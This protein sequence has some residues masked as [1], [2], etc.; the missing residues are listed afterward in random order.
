M[1]LQFLLTRLV[2]DPLTNVGGAAI[3]KPDPSDPLSLEI[4]RDLNLI[5]TK[6]CKDMKQYSRSKGSTA[7]AAASEEDDFDD[8]YDS[9]GASGGGS[10]SGSKKRKRGVEVESTEEKRK[11]QNRNAAAKY[12]EKK[13]VKSVEIEENIAN[14]Q[15][16]NERLRYELER[17]GASL[18]WSQGTE[19]VALLYTRMRIIKANVDALDINDAKN[20]TKEAFHELFSRT[21]LVRDQRNKL[22][23]QAC[24]LAIQYSKPFKMEAAAERFLNP[25]LSNKIKPDGS[26]DTRA[27]DDEEVDVDEDR[28]PHSPAL[29]SSESNTKALLMQKSIRSKFYNEIGLTPEQAMKVR[30]I[31][32]EFNINAQERRK[33]RAALLSA[34]AMKSSVTE[35]LHELKVMSR[36][37]LA[38]R[39]ALFQMIF[40]IVTP[41]QGVRMF[42]FLQ[43]NPAINFDG[44]TGNV[45]ETPESLAIEAGIPSPK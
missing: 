43:R 6:N 10:K 35:M 14:L 32:V 31:L 11:A 13:K 29:E 4:Q 27:S 34:H 44:N 3:S 16:E 21:N 40:N 22:F 12:R 18:A 45:F 8:V 24:D 20:F 39:S 41:E 23:E 2:N 37:Y 38:A 1:I 26:L 25:P 5:I 30:R 9:G 36:E 7:A 19:E 17:L 42:V 15:A 33:A 28:V